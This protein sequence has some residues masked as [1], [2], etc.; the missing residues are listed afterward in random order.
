MRKTVNPFGRMASHYSGGRLGVEAARHLGS[1]EGTSP[2]PG[3]CLRFG[4]SSP[5]QPQHILTAQFV[6]GP[7]GS[8]AGAFPNKVER[9]ALQ[10]RRQ[11]VGWFQAADQGKLMGFGSLCGGASQ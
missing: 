5:E 1:A 8:G 4:Q 6:P 11:A 10:V 3:A 9:F 7:L 2:N